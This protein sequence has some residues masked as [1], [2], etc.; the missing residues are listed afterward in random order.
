MQNSKSRTNYYDLLVSKDGENWMLVQ[1]MAGVAPTAELSANDHAFR[2]ILDGAELD[3]RYVKIVLR[4]NITGN[5]DNRDK[6]GIGNGINE[7]TIYG[8]E[9]DNL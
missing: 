4:G 2:T 9:L 7:I 3:A 8:T 5:T 6:A 1:E